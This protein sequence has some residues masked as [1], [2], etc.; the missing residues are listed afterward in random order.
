[1]IGFFKR[2]YRLPIALIACVIALTCLP[3]DPFIALPVLLIP[4]LGC[5]LSVVH[6][7]E[8]LAHKLGEPYG[9]VILT[10]SVTLIEVVAI[11]AMMTHGP[12]NPAVAR[13]TIYAVVM[14]LL[15]FTAGACL[16]AGGWRHMELQFNLQGANTYLGVI[17]PLTVFSLILPDFTYTTV[18]P[19]LSAAQEIF[20]GFVCIGLYV[21]FL[22]V[23]TI[24]H[25]AYFAVADI[26]HEP[27][28]HGGS[29]A[30]I[31]A[32]MLICYMAPLMFL[33]EE[34]GGP[35]ENLLGRWH[36]PLALGG[37]IIAFLVVTPEALGAVRA[38]MANQLQRSVNIFMGSVLSSIGLTIPAMLL[39]GWITGLRLEL[40]LPASA[41]V[42][43][44][45]T[46]AVSMMTFASGRTNVMQG[47]VHIVLFCA[48]ILLLFQG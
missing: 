40:G 17:L 26:M 13:D 11:S 25:R 5:S 27:E 46:L 45:L 24:R 41:A 8:D 16:L 12:Q 31:S 44:V 19:T 48:Y 36:W 9:T 43:L 37:T 7:A 1:M 14:I 21:A 15:N 22:A 42:T 6:H 30:W 28:A 38:A 32:L 47:V 10:L 4:A 3:H 18:G 29:S 23:Q 20:I 35:I 34:M 33:A 39:L 2:E